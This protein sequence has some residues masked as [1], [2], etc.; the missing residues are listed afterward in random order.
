MR[1]WVWVFNEHCLATFPSL[2]EQEYKH[3]VHCISPRILEPA[4]QA[5]LSGPVP[6]APPIVGPAHEGI[7][8]LDSERR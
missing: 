7:Q 6:L 4:E 2:Q 3:N 1:V 5:V 8:D